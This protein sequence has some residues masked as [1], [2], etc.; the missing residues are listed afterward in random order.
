MFFC[1]CRPLFIS[2]PLLLGKITHYF[3]TNHYFFEIIETNLCAIFVIFNREVYNFASY[4]SVGDSQLR[5][6]L[7]CRLSTI[8]VLD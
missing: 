7:M 1:K 6:N 4:C 8:G 5:D 3:D 2:V